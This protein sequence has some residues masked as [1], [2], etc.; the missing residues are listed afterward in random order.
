L[1]YVYSNDQVKGEWS[2]QGNP[3]MTGHTYKSTGYDKNLRSLV[4]APHE[5]TYFFDPIA[6][7]WSRSPEKNPYRAD[8]YSVT[9]CST[10]DGAVVWAD[11]RNGGGDGLW[12]LDSSSRNWR[13]LPIEGDKL[14]TKSPDQHGLAFDSLRNRLLFFSN[15][16]KNKGDVLSYD[17]KSSQSKWLGAGGKNKAKVPS[18]ETVYHPELDLVVLAAKTRVNDNQRWL[19]YDCSANAWRG[20]DLKGDDPIGKGTSGGVF[21]NSVGMMYDPN[22]R[23]IWFVGQ[24][25]EVHALKLESSSIK[26]ELLE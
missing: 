11:K 10:P 13:E 20:L 7:K 8:F 18:R 14:P 6:G 15:A 22:R 2:F 21:H 25:S 9:V 3:W 1:E 5:Y 17:L 4:F 16:D 24:N 19:A 23:L 12:Q 26:S